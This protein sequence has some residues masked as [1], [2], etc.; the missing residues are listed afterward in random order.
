MPL[1]SFRN[2]IQ[3]LEAT[4]VNF[5][6]GLPEAPGSVSAGFVL[7]PSFLFAEVYEQ[8]VSVAWTSVAISIAITCVVLITFT[9]NIIVSALATGTIGLV[10][11]W[12]CGLMGMYGW[13]LDPYIATCITILVGFSVD[14]VVHMAMGYN[15]SNVD[16]RAGKVAEALCT[17]GISVTAGALSTAGAATLLLF[18]TIVFFGTFGKFILSAICSAYLFAI[19]FFRLLRVVGPEGGSGSIS[20]LLK[21]RCHTVQSD[22]SV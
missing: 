9:H 11:L 6:D 18:A 7:S 12:V 4:W 17:M 14:Y 5:V 20:S 3:A 16:E 15:E 21:D 13:D 19:V 1:V 2:D 10:V 8:A 22:L